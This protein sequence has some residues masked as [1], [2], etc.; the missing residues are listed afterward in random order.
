LPP[1]SFATYIVLAEASIAGKKFFAITHSAVRTDTYASTTESADFLL[2][3]LGLVRTSSERPGPLPGMVLESSVERGGFSLEGYAG[4]DERAHS[5][6]LWALGD[7]LFRRLRV[8]W[9]GVAVPAPSA[10]ARSPS[11][12]PPV[13]VSVEVQGNVTCTKSGSYV[14]C[15]AEQ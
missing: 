13:A 15:R 6:H 8:H 2:S 14:E 7:T 9:A 1:D 4:G 12:G 10:S 11:S 5:Q 3:R